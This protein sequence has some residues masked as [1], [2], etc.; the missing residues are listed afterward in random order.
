[1]NATA[2]ERGL[3]SGKEGCKSGGSWRHPQAPGVGRGKVARDGTGLVA[4]REVC[5]KA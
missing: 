3:R 4:D 1:M 5:R 2:G